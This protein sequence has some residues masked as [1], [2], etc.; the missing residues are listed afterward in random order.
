MGPNGEETDSVAIV[1]APASRDLAALHHRVPVTIASEEFERWL[2]GLA[3]DADDVMP[4]LR[5]G[6]AEFAGTRFPPRQPRRQ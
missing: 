3:Y 1:T 6:R 4:L 5:T 2:D